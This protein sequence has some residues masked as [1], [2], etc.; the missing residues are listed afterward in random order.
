[1]S[2]IEITRVGATQVLRLNRPEKK[3]ALTASMYDALSDALEAGDKDAGVAAHVFLGC[4]GV[5]TAGNDIGEFLTSSTGGETVLGAVLRFVRA[6]PRVEKPML[7]GVDGLAVGIGTTLLFHCDLVYASP[8]ARFQTPFLDLGLVP[9]AGSSLL[10]PAR[11]GY[12]RSF[13]MLVLG[14]A[15][16]AT[17]M[18]GAG[19]VNAIVSADELEAQVMGVAAELARKP[20]AALAQARRLMRGDAEAVSRRTDEEAAIFA[21][22]LQSA[23]AREAFRAFLEKRAPD[24]S[25]PRDS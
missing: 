8:A 22:Q 20:P 7:A 6:L 21:R 11:L 3:N 4:N 18:H 25:N 15:I 2:N 1:M 9:E 24:F 14:K 17:A 5:F 10:M 19:L 23:E 16:D 13:E 12:A